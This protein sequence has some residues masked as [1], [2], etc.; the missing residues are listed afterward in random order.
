MSESTNPSSRLRMLT[1]AAKLSSVLAALGV[2]NSILL[3][4]S[5]AA[6]EKKEEVK[7]LEMKATQVDEAGLKKLLE[8]AMESGD[9]AAAIDKFGKAAKLNDNQI[10]LLKGLSKEDLKDV[11]KIQEYLN[12]GKDVPFRTRRG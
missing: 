11:K 2:S 6:K 7:P 12:G 3:D 1:T 5:V 4:D 8:H 9:M 10:K